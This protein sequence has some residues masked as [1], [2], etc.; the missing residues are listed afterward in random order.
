MDRVSWGYYYSHIY[1][2]LVK[3]KYPLA[4]HLEGNK[5]SMNLGRWLFISKVLEINIFSQL[6]FFFMTEL[7]S[8]SSQ[9]YAFNNC[10]D[11]FICME[12]IKFRVQVVHLYKEDTRKPQEQLLLIIP[13]SCAL[14]Q[15]CVVE[16][17]KIQCLKCEA[18]NPYCK[19]GPQQ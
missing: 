8:N 13:K 17:C 6:I 1:T 16:W 3:R 7:T 4:E 2:P 14:T 19:R 12:S 11:S 10:P 5:T 18:M 9:P 15:E